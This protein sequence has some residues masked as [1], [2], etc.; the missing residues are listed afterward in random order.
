MEYEG[1][2]SPTKVALDLGLDLG[3]QE[4]ATRNTEVKDDFDKQADNVTCGRCGWENGE[5]Y[6]SQQEYEKAGSM[7][8]RTDRWPTKDDFDSDYG[9]DCPGCGSDLSESDIT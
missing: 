3:R 5:F 7:D 1:T 9:R 2:L 6:D 4:P 8:V